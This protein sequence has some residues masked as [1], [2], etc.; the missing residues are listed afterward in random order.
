MLHPR[1]N[2]DISLIACR[3]NGRTALKLRYRE[4]AEN[5]I[6]PPEQECAPRSALHLRSTDDCVWCSARSLGVGLDVAVIR[7]DDNAEAVD[8][9]A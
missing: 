1:N 6:H 5:L 4:V 7:K 8:E 9:A 2:A 3:R